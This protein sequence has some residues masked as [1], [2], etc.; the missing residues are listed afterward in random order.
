L[1]VPGHLVEVV[2][3]NRRPVVVVVRP[4][5]LQALRDRLWEHL[6]LGVFDEF[7]EA[8]DEDVI[9]NVGLPVASDVVV[10]R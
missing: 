3:R 6:T 10:H 2:G 7:V 9:T 4:E 8:R 5:H 1:H